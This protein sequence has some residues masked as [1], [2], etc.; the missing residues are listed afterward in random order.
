MLKTLLLSAAGVAPSERGAE[1]RQNCTKSI[2]LGLAALVVATGASAYPMDIEHN[3][4]WLVLDGLPQQASG[5]AWDIEVAQ[6]RTRDWAQRGGVDI[7]AVCGTLDAKNPDDGL[8]N[9][10]VFYAADDDGN[11]LP[12]GKPFFYGTRTDDSLD[13]QLGAAQAACAAEPE[14]TIVEALR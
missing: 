8:T 1:K 4:R 10:V 7:A 5:A 14:A 11:I 13:L 2:G 3:A 9:F 6:L 12:V